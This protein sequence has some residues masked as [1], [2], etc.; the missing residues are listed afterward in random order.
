[1]FDARPEDYGA[2]L[3]PGGFVNPDV[4]RQSEA[5]LTFVRRMEQLGRPIATLCHGPKVIVF[6]RD[7]VRAAAH[8]VA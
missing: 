8:V 6:A 5:A 2:L 4:L 7:R 1:M 3:L